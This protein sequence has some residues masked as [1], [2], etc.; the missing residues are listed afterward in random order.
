MRV[1]VDEMLLVEES[2]LVEAMRLSAATL[3]ILI[4][5]SGAAGLAAILEHDPPGRRIATVLTGSV[6]RPEHFALLR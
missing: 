5:P 3:G 2:A 6:L 4:E 1:L